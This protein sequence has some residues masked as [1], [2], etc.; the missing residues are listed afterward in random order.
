MDLERELVDALEQHR[1]PVGGRDGDD[2]GVEAGLERLV[3]QQA[4]A[5]AVHGVDGKL[6][7]A[8]LELV[9]DAG[10]QARRRRPPRP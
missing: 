1:Q 7:E 6:L 8:A 9:L 5:E 2:E 10:A 4:R 3:A